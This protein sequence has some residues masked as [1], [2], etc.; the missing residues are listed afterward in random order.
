MQK[1]LKHDIQR[2][3]K[4]IAKLGRP[5]IP[6]LHIDAENGKKY[7]TP[8][9]VAVGH[10]KTRGKNIDIKVTITFKIETRC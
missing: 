4:N 2:A 3:R 6:R 8:Q 10:G 5:I 7:L 9:L 1:A